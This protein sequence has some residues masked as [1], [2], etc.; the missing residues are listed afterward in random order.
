MSENKT[1][2]PSISSAADSPAKTSHLPAKVLALLALEAAFGTN[3]SASSASSRPNGSLLKTSRAARSAGLTTCAAT[4]N[5]SAMKAYRYRLAL[6]MS[7]HHIYGVESS[8][9]P[10]P[11]ASNYGSNRGGAAGR[12]GPVRLSLSLRATR[13]FSDADGE[14]EPAVTFDAQM[15]GLRSVAGGASPWAVAPEF[16]RVDDGISVRLDPAGRPLINPGQLRSYRIKAL[17]NAVVPQ[18]AEVI[19]HLVKL[20]A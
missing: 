11:T 6:K 17:G 20:L 4:W 13:A 3:T 1:L 12:S 9:L 16:R 15:A 5:G 14:G 18:C 19:G 10:T 8:L 7:A 2:P